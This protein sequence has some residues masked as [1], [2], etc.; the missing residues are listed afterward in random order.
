MIQSI[1][2]LLAEGV[3]RSTFEWGRIQSNADWIPPIGLCLAIMLFVRYMYRRDAVELPLLLSWLLTA[4]RTAVFFG[5]LIIYLQP[6]WRMEREIV[7]NSKVAL[8]VDT[9]MSMGLSDDESTAN[10]P[11]S[12]ENSDKVA[13]AKTPANIRLNRITAM[14]DE[15]DFI[16]QLSATHDV[17]VYQFNDDLKID[18]AVTLNK[19]QTTAANGDNTAFAEPTVQQPE[20]AADWR[21]LLTPAGTETKL[22]QALR[23]LILKER[24][25][26]LSGIVVF[27]DGGQN[28]GISPE[29]AIA[30]SQEAKLPIFTVGLGSDK[31]PKNVR[32]SDFIV[33]ARAYPGDRYTITGFLQARHKAGEVVTI[34]VLSRPAGSSDKEEGTG[35][36]LDTRQVT[37]GGD[38][39]IVPVKF[40]LTPDSLGRRT[41]CVRVQATGDENQSD[42][43]R[44]AEIE[45]VD[46]KNHVLLLASGPMRDYQYLRTLLYRDRST[47]LDVMVQTGLEGMSQEGKIITE[48]PT[49]KQSM[50]D[51]DC[52]VAFDPNWQALSAQQVELLENWVADQG[53]GLIVVAGPIYTGAPINGW[54]QN[55]AMTPSE[56]FIPWNFPGEFHRPKTAH[57]SHPNPRPWISLEKASRPI[58]LPSAIRPPR[59]AKP[60]PNFPAFIATARC[61]KQNPARQFMPNCPIRK[62]QAANSHC[63]CRDNFTDRAEFFIWVAEKCGG[64]ARSKNLISNNFIQT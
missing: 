41:I 45:I 30:M 46:R 29:T 40:E 10:R 50:Y 58:S 11:A 12:T 25:S 9:S 20:N 62:P 55:N 47:T 37:L 52:V 51:Y 27:S 4:L 16:K 5:L 35:K 24:G 36:V 57:I 22:G 2:P 17:V 7:R 14:L 61:G 23:D 18:R 1:L 44:E 34:E 19:N 42:N 60:G 6:Q 53:G 63:I 39:E 49:T 64:F 38:G 59:A 32:V 28:A 43:F 13:A 48:F 56:I 33:P 3:S 8:L 15:S 54:T 26:P 21:K 31:Q